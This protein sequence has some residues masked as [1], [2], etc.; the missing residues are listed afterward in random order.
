MKGILGMQSLKIF[1]RAIHCWS[2]CIQNPFEGEV[3][4]DIVSLL[5]DA[6][7]GRNNQ[8]FNVLNILLHRG[9]KETAYL[10][11][12]LGVGSFYFI[13]QGILFGKCLSFVPLRHHSA[14]NHFPD[15]YI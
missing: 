3:L 14:S 8:T 2:I 12:A 7:G 10:C 9:I 5:L 15:A 11:R 13:S 1:E 6:M 4:T